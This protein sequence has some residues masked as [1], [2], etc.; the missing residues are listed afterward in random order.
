M[1]SFNPF[2]ANI[3]KRIISPKLITN[4][5]GGYDAK[6]DLTNINTINITGDII[7]PVGSYLN[8]GFTLQFSEGSNIDIPNNTVNL[9]SNDVYFFPGINNA[10][11]T[12]TQ[13]NKTGLY[14]VIWAT[15]SAGNFYNGSS[16]IYHDSNGFIG[17]FDYGPNN[18]IQLSGYNTNALSYKNLTGNVLNLV[19]KVYYCS[20]S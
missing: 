15:F 1:A 17:G 6:V 19:F 14:L 20:P 8:R 5:S 2:S 4:T 13:F 12:A 10:A 3:L 18:G 7:G 11:A 9:Q 16:I